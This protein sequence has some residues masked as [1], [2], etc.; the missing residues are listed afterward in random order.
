MKEQNTNTSSASGVRNGFYG[1]LAEAEKQNNIK[2]ILIAAG[3]L[4]LAV[5][6]LC[7]AVHLETNAGRYIYVYGEHQQKIRKNLAYSDDFLMIDMN[8]LAN[9]AGIEKTAT[10][11]QA[12]YKINGTVA[13][14][15][16]GKNTA[17]VNGI[18]IKMSA[19]ALIKNGYCLIPLENAEDILV[20]VNFV[21]NKKTITFNRKNENIYMIAKEPHVEYE[22]DMDKY[23]SAINSDD[24]YI[25]ILVNKEHSVDENYPADKDSLIEIPAK[26]RK[27]DVIYLYKD[28]EKAL[29]ALMQDAFALG[30]TDTYVTSAYRSYSY[31]SMLFYDIY[32]KQEMQ[33]GLSESDA[34]NKVLTYSQRPGESEHQTGLC[35]DFTTRGIGGVL[36]DTFETTEVFK[37]LKD[38]AWKYGFIL[39]YPK[40]K[41][42]ITGISYESW[43]YRFVGLQRAS[44]IYQTGMCYEEYLE[45][46]EK[47]E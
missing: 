11:T 36:E 29:E 30:Y 27:S 26:Y 7:T 24:D 25:T 8:S 17:L 34:I 42:D 45:Y 37:W 6:L 43:H 35:V 22:T 23:W 47:G 19:K 41:S 14:F 28:A 2:F 9:Y 13:T 1:R 20:G 4:S 33:N 3:I 39:R 16:N 15:E 38:N 5:I 10:G 46:F 12:T 32:V 44:I 31:Q 21:I 18:E 40:E